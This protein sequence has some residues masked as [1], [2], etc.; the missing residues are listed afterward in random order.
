[1]PGIIVRTAAFAAAGLLLTASLARAADEDKKISRDSVPKKVMDP[2]NHRFPGAEVTGVEK[3]TENGNVVYDFEL[4]HKGR[5]YEMDV[6]EDGTVMEIEKE[7]KGKEVPA[8]VT[9]AVQAKYPKAK[10]K[11]VMEVDT[12]NGNREKPDHYEVSLATADKKEKEVTVSL[13]G[14]DVKEEA[15]DEADKK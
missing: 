8:A 12:V 9:T 14:T 4:K 5:K 2:V 15:A 13:D 11:E 3:E 6:K 7:V 1:M 10:I